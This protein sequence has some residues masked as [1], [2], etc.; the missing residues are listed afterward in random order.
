MGR[1]GPI[2][3]RAKITAW[4]CSPCGRRHRYGRA[5]ATG[6]CHVPRT[7][8]TSRW[9]CESRD[10]LCVSSTTTTASASFPDATWRRPVDDSG[11]EL[12]HVDDPPMQ[13]ST[14]CS[15]VDVPS[16]EKF[17]RQIEAG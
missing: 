3:R 4:R 9:Y 7:A 2:T 15:L 13:T 5:A 14:W 6:G 11:L 1:P 12:V 8:L 10:G 16:A 17:R